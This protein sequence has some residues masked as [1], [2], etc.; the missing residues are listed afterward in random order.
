MLFGG[1]G[2]GFKSAIRVMGRISLKRAG[3]GALRCRFNVAN[4][5]YSRSLFAAITLSGKIGEKR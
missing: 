5:F 3:N 1:N 2:C 4:E